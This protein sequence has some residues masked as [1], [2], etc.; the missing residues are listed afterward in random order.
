MARTSP[1]VTAVGLVLALAT[2]GPAQ[3]RPE[4]QAEA[5]QATIREL[6]PMMS[7]TLGITVFEPIPLRTVNRDQ[8]KAAL[9]L[10]L[11]QRL[12]DVRH[13]EMDPKPVVK[14]VLIPERA[15]QIAEIVAARLAPRYLIRF[16][17]D[18]ESTLLVAPENLGSLLDPKEIPSR[19]VPFLVRFALVR[20]LTR[21]ADEETNRLAEKGPAIHETVEQLAARLA[22]EEGRAWWAASRLIRGTFRPPSLG[23]TEAAPVKS[24]G[25][26]EAEQ[27]LYA[28][29]GEGAKRGRV[30][31]EQ[32]LAGGGTDAVSQRVSSPP[33]AFSELPELPAAQPIPQRPKDPLAEAG[34]ALADLHP[35][36]GWTTTTD[37]PDL[38]MVTARLGAELPRHQV[39]TLIA[40]LQR[41]FERSATHPA[42]GQIHLS[43]AATT[44]P[45]AAY[46]WQKAE[47]Q[48]LA[49]RTR[50]MQEGG[51]TVEETERRTHDLPGFPVLTVTRT[52]AS[53]DGETVKVCRMLAVYRNYALVLTCTDHAVTWDQLRAFLLA[54]RAHLDEAQRFPG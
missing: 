6:I 51:Y 35:G 36:D 49:V 20:E 40:G 27:L 22:F 21:L 5:L 3:P 30:W 8:L 17:Y 25:E 10:D 4:L 31:V 24:T 53:A 54:V 32:L 1:Y 39:K 18:G 33:R 45:S 44:N 9:A 19:Q 13:V 15:R 37:E 43:I 28:I 2:S 52:S 41:V 16:A 23:E 7:R 48:R 12:L 29:N 38:K 11:Q 47:E 46:A 50:S 14:P 42:L 26:V 34:K